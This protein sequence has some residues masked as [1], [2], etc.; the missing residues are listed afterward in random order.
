L[1]KETTPSHVH[2]AYTA[3]ITQHHPLVSVGKKKEQ[4]GG[5]CRFRGS[6]LACRSETCS[7]Y[8]WVLRKAQE[9][10]TPN[11]ADCRRKLAINTSRADPMVRAVHAK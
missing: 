8:G 7:K 2:E 4:P 6:T 3:T 1:N 9:A 5:V 10:V 11:L